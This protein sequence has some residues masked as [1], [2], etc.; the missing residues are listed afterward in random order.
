MHRSKG[1]ALHFSWLYLVCASSRNCRVLERF[2][3]LQCYGL[4]KDELVGMEEGAEGCRQAC[5]ADGKCEV[6][7]FNAQFGCYRGNPY[8]CMRSVE[9]FADGSLGERLRG[10]NN[11]A[12]YWFGNLQD[13]AEYV[14]LDPAASG[15]REQIFEGL[16]GES[17]RLR[18]NRSRLEVDLS[19]WSLDRRPEWCCTADGLC[20]AQ[21]SGLTEFCCKEGMSPDGQI[22]YHV[23]ARITGFL[24]PRELVAFHKLLPEGKV[25]E[26]AFK[27]SRLRALG[28]HHPGPLCASAS[29]TVDGQRDIV[30]GSAALLPLALLMAAHTTISGTFVNIGAGTCLHPD[31]LY[32]LLS[33]PQGGGFLGLA[34]E[35]DSAR[36][37]RCEAEMSQTFATVVPVCLSL[38]PTRAG[39]QLLPYLAGMFP[40]VQ[41]PWPL[42]FLVV[43]IDGCDCLIVEDLMQFVRPKVMMLEIA[44]QFPPP[45]RFSLHWDIK[46]SDSWQSEYDVDKFNP[47]SG[48]SL[49]YAL[50]KFKPFGY[51][52]LRLLPTDAILVHESV[53][54]I[55]EEG[56]GL[57]F[58]QDEFLCYRSSTLWA[59]MPGTYVREWFYVPHPS[60]AFSQIWANI[61]LVNKNMGREGAPFTL[62]F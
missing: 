27:A 16:S 58:P 15:S 45:F 31:P 29:T 41:P 32:Q 13:Y 18:R 56:L 46:R 60:L 11:D 38:E 30:D 54:S 8:V 39:H 28:H 34:V 10:A 42:D 19:C 2:D 57:K 25:D 7:Q 37:Q 35:A 24:S 14:D 23:Y 62:D 17:Y 26:V 4:E 12:L 5:C 44:F 3:G 55:M 52:L 40:K 20:W 1:W 33:S 6:W 53:Q 48:C 50:H 49:S 61:S 51:H 36:L 9:P 22:L 59:Q 43:D 47:V 21:G